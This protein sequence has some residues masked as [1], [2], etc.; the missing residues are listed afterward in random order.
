M[1]SKDKVFVVGIVLLALVATGLF[2]GAGLSVAG[3]GDPRTPAVESDHPRE[4][5]SSRE[6]SPLYAQSLNESITSLES[7]GAARE[8]GTKP[9]SGQVP[10][11]T[12]RSGL[13]QATSSWTCMVSCSVTCAKDTC[14]GDACSPGPPSDGNNSSGSGADAAG[15]IGGFIVLLAIGGVVFYFVRKRKMTA[16]AQ[17]APGAPAAPGGQGPAGGMTVALPPSGRQPEGAEGEKPKPKFCTACGAA[18]PP[19]DKF[20][21]FCGKPAGGN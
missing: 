1:E 18:I 10:A 5:T 3:A 11:T 19:T 16:Q 17:A 13:G 14:S 6:G 7:N 15:A 9:A 2:C 8:S 12:T 4:T 21:K 20:C